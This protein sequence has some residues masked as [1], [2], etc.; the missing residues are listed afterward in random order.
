MPDRLTQQLA[1]FAEIDKVKQIVRR[2]L[3]M[4]GSRFENDA[5]HSWHMAL[6]ALGLTEYAAEP[7]AAL[8]VVKM[9]LIHDVVEIDAGDAYAYDPAAQVGQ[10]DRERRAAARIFGLLPPDQA[11]E[12]CGLW[13]EFEAQASADARYAAALDR[14][15][16]VLANY[17][18]QGRSWRDHGV[19]RSQ[20]LARIQAVRTGAPRLWEHLCQIVAD[21]TQRGWLRAD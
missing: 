1:F 7:V 5:E 20:V 3:L 19:T 17:H 18:A 13:E 4:D 9:C 2:T 16:S 8:R 14:V 11:A 6:M 21:A 12:W 15:Q 10:A